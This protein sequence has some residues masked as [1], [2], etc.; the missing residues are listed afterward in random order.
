VH[1]LHVDVEVDLLAK[2]LAAQLA[3]VGPFLPMDQLDVLVQ[4][5]LGRRAV[6]TLI[7]HEGTPGA[8]G[9]FVLAVRVRPRRRLALDYVG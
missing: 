7:A 6:G 8:H 5:G 4:Q 1:G 2:P 9:L 3:R